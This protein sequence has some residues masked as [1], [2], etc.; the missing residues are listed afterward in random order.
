MPLA[1]GDFAFD[2]ER[3]QL[4]RAGQPVRLEPKAYDLLGL[5]LERRP[6]ALSKTQI[7]D[8][9]WPATAVSDTALAGL[10]TDLRSALDD[11]ARQPRF[12]RTVHGFGYAFCGEAH[13][14]P[15]GPQS[16]AAPALVETMAAPAASRRPWMRSVSRRT[17][18][19]AAAL[20]FLAAGVGTRF[21]VRAWR[22]RASE[23]L[24]AVA[25]TTFPGAELH[26]SLSPDGSY[27]TFTW[28]GGEQGAPDVYVQMIGSGPPLRITNS[29]AAEVNPVWSPDGRWIAFLRPLGSPAPAD[30]RAELRIIPPLGGSER[31]VAEIYI[32]ALGN[33]GTPGFLAW[34]PDSTCLIAADG[35][36]DR[37]PLALVAVSLETGAKR[38]LTHPQV[39]AFGD[40]NP[41]VSP[42][43]RS[44]VF[45]R[46]P[47][48]SAG[49]LYRLRLR[50]DVTAD[51]EPER[52][53]PGRLNAAYPAWM[54]DGDEIVFSA[55]GSLW[56]LAAATLGAG[57]PPQRLPYVGDDGMM[58]VVA[59]PTTGR[60][61]RLVYV[62][63]VNDWNIWRIESSGAGA[64]A[65]PPVMA[66][67]STRLDANPSLSP[68]GRRVA[69]SSNRSGSMEIWVADLDG[70]NAE[71]LTSFESVSSSPRWSPDGQLVAFQSNRE[72]QFDV[73][74]VPSAG[75][76]PSN[77][78]SHP[79]NDFSPSFSRDGRWVFFSSTRGD[80]SFRVWKTPVSG[81]EA[82]QV[83]EGSGY[84]PEEGA[85]GSLYY[86]HDA[87]TP[88]AVLR[89]PPGRGRPTQVLD[90]VIFHA[91]ALVDDG[92][93]YVD[94]ADGE[95]RLRY[96]N[97]A[98]GKSGTVASGLGRVTA[99]ITAA[100]DGRTVLFSRQDYSRQDLVLVEDFR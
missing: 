9:I 62:H 93:Y 19:I 74:L 14:S 37:L 88:S 55:K 84:R 56:R 69:F 50:P 47:G 11:S 98:D 26:P 45:R 27:V 81:G 97:L 13:E 77:L 53:T 36:G 68:D 6:N 46:V 34:C 92:I 63:N 94:R 10:V 99:L 72:G 5:L 44:L 2:R 54:P 42:D 80:G 15:D 89:A 66:I 86:A 100:P 57:G 71:Q 7:R 23:P 32:D 61:T 83:S 40:C 16:A 49:E 24:K 4:L 52:L 96:L 60:P 8:A 67:S 29:P 17:V 33:P 59:R 79:A 39:P 85:D 1:F 18:S 3:R 87:N 35:T 28:T 41:A 43:G 73:W 82:V 21:L 78:T 70:A 64:A 38:P 76:K 20:G 65:A 25:L 95:T 51:G 91:F 90:A 12:I 48:P 31:K 75:G 58:P 22:A 30:G